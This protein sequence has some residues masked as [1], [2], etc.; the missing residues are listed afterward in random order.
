MD[1]N[2]KKSVLKMD[3]IDFLFAVLLG[4]LKKDLQTGFHKKRSFSANY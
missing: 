1:F 4:S 3:F 2:T